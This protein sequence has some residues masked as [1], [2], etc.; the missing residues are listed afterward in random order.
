MAI[1][2]P[3]YLNSDC[4]SYI[5]RSADCAQAVKQNPATDRWFITINHPGFNTPANNHDGYATKTRAL[6]AYHKHAR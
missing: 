2:I 5:C 1:E 6:A 3:S 4:T